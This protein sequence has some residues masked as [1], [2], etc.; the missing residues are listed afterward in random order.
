MEKNIQKCRRR[1]IYTKH[2]R[3]QKNT[4]DTVILAHPKSLADAKNLAHPKSLADAKN[5][6][7]PKSLAPT[8]ML[9]Q[10]EK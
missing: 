1:K 7:H 6:M 2:W 4:G 9:A 5:L 10:Q 8:E 3:I